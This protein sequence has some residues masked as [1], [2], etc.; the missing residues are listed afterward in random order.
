ML[1]RVFRG[2][3][4]LVGAF[5]INIGKTAMKQILSK[6]FLP[7]LLSTAIVFTGCNRGDQRS[8]GPPA[9][10]S[11]PAASPKTVFETDLEWVRKGQYT[12]VWVFSRKDGK[13]L[14]SEDG[15]YLR[16]NAPQVVDWVTTDE[17]RK[18]IAG[19]NFD[20]AEGNLPLLQKR[21]NAED[22]SAR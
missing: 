7:L 8:A 21:F 4:F 2:S 3:L 12:Y 22:Y 17:G 5:W 13:P 20:L 18:V 10:A 14:D 19:T 9:N 16:Q 1:F 6:G 15:N 11:T